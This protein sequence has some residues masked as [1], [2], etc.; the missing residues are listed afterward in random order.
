MLEKNSHDFIYWGNKVIL[1]QQQEQNVI[2]ISSFAEY[3][4]DD[5]NTLDIY[6]LPQDFK[7]VNDDIINAGQ[8]KGT[9]WVRFI[10]INN[11]TKNDWLLKLEN[12]ILDE[13]TL[14]REIAPGSFEVTGNR[15]Y[16][17]ISSRSV[18]S[19]DHRFNL[20]LP[21]NQPA[22]FFLKVHCNTP[23]SF[24]LTTGTK[25]AYLENDEKNLLIRGIFLGIF[26]LMAFYNL[27]I[28][29]SVKDSAYLYYVFYTLLNGFFINYFIGTSNA[30]LPDNLFW[31]NK[32]SVVIPS[33]GVIALIFFSIKFLNIVQYS[34][35]LYRFSLML[36]AAMVVII[37]INILG[38]EYWSSS[39]R[40][41]ANYQ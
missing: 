37:F 28:Y 11:S 2:N 17:P 33:L 14:Y 10:I 16:L 41:T 27:F 21:H 35:F 22:L 34:R 5:G 38:Y 13:V 20:N 40:K 15:D 29:F 36:A 4:L 39:R 8:Y 18:K 1:T 26:L 9:V 24:K 30:F 25:I 3:Y 32:Y 23:L 19:I 31:I 7:K 12:P 6:S